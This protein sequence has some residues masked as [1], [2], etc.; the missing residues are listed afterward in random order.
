MSNTT[1][2]KSA[3][4]TL[5]LLELVAQKRNGLTFTEIQEY[6]DMPKSS[7]HSLIQELIENGYLIFNEQKK[8]YYAGIEFIK[9]CSTCIK[10]TDLIEE[11]GILTGNIGKELSLTTH[12]GILDS[13]SIMYLAKHETNSGFSLMNS[14]GLKLPAHC[15]SLGKMLLSE[16][17]TE[18]IQEL[19]QNYNFS[20]EKMTENS[21]DSLD[22]LFT[23]LDHIKSQGYA[24]E[25]GEANTYAACIS[26][27][28]LVNG[29]MIASV[30]AT[31][32]IEAYKNIDKKMVIDTM[33]KNISVT[34]QRMFS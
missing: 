18:S 22:K 4:R 29:K 28:I 15:T 7:T 11:L 24:E 17:S 6:L 14:V 20:L 8:N 1:K 2:V 31:L 30:S 27:P 9:L 33:K 23:E 5:R 34:E 25:I 19:Y 13:R 26:L 16:Y 32:P 3:K 12:A 10:N 21:L